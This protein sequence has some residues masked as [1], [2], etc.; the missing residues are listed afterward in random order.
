M[1]VILRYALRLVVRMGSGL[2][3]F[4]VMSTGTVGVEF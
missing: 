4:M 3:W 1:M 2:N